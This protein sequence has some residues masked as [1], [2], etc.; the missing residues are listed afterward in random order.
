[1]K[2]SEHLN[3]YSMDISQAKKL[4]RLIDI[5]RNVFADYTDDMKKP[6]TQ[7]IA[8]PIEFVAVFESMIPYMDDARVLNTQL[9]LLDIMEKLG[10]EYTKSEDFQAVKEK[11]LTKLSRICSI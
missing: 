9:K 7:E 3:C 5:Y 4:S 2:I 1:M 8:D 10:L 11:A 6:H